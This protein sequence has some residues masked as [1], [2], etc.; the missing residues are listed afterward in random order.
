MTGATAGTL[1]AVAMA[2]SCDVSVNASVVEVS[3]PSSSEY[4]AYRA[5]RKGWQVLCN[6]LVSEVGDNVDMVGTTVYL[7]FGLRNGSDKRTGTAICTEW[8]ATAT[9]GNLIQ[10][11]FI[12]LGSGALS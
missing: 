4:R 11:S 7:S 9:K 6:C 12:F 1:T 5:G 10:G 8:K 2:K 3:D